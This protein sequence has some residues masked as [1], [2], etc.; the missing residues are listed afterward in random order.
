MNGS[1]RNAR[2]S[3]RLV[4]MWTMAGEWMWFRQK[5]VL[6]VWLFFSAVFTPHQTHCSWV[7]GKQLMSVLHCLCHFLTW[8]QGN[9]SLNHTQHQP[10]K[11]QHSPSIIFYKYRPFRVACCYFCYCC[12]LTLQFSAVILQKRKKSKYRYTIKQ[13][14]LLCFVVWIH[15]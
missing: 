10:T 13:I 2:S 12:C 1:L 4:F 14:Q 3:C 6:Q 5:A 9:F 7:S 15:D 11:S 8:P